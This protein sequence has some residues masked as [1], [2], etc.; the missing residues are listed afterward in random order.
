MRRRRSEPDVVDMGIKCVV[1]IEGIGILSDF[2]GTIDH[3]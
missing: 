3:R 2:F 1:D